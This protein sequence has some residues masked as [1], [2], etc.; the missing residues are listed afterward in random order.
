MNRSIIKN[1]AYCCI[2]IH[3]PSGYE[4]NIWRKGE[5]REEAIYWGGRLLC[6]AGFSLAIAIVSASLSFH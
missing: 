4:G 3:E 6:A 2:L 5:W 1:D